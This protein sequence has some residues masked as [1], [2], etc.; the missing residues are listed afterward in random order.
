[1]VVIIMDT[2]TK[3]LS[4]ILKHLSSFLQNERINILQ[5][6]LTNVLTLHYIVEW[7]SW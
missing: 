2:T 1:M 7:Y 3:L 6:A 5:K 4:I